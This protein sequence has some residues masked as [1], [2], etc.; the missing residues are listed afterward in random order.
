MAFDAGRYALQNWRIYRTQLEMIRRPED[1]ATLQKRRDGFLAQVRKY[2]PHWEQECLD[3]DRIFGVAPGS[4]MDALCFGCP[5][6]Q[7]SHECTSWIVMPEFTGGK[8][9]HL[10]KNR[11]ANSRHLTVLQ[12]AVPGKHAWTGMGNTGSLTPTMGV[13]DAGLA[14]AMNSGEKTADFNEGGFSTPALARIL[15]EECRTAEDAVQLLETMILDKAYRHGD[16]GSIWFIA[17]GSGAFIAE[18]N[19]AAFA[20][21]PVDGIGVRANFWHYPE[22]RPHSTEDPAERLRQRSRENTAYKILLDEGLLPRQIITAADH[23]KASRSSEVYGDSRALCSYTT[24][25]ASLFSIDCEFPGELTTAWLACGP[26]RRALYIPI[27]VAVSNLPQE[28]LNGELADAFFANAWEYTGKDPARLNTRDVPTDELEK[29]ESI[30][31]K[32]HTLAVENA[33]AL[34]K[35]GRNTEAAAV[36]EEAFRRN[37]DLVKAFALPGK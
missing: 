16:R 29:T 1:A 31:E 18:H 30:L 35:D 37:W 34:L 33:R 8:Q 24:N 7:T 26:P 22:M 28:L 2:A 27:P 12:V 5:V 3:I 19:A 15:L 20:A 14:I 36:L 6:P 10:H 9:L 32:N 21:H 11:D 17:D 13:N 25:S 23:R 4:S